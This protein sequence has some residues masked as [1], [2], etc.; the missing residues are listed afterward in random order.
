MAEGNGKF[1]FEEETPGDCQWT[2]VVVIGPERFSILYDRQS[3]E[4][5][6]SPF[7]RLISSSQT[8]LTIRTQAPRGGETDESPPL[9]DFPDRRRDFH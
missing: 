7:R 6:E 1:R 5:F 8:T 9:A 3:S 2:E 4:S